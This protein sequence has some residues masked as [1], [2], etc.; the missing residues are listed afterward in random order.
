MELDGCPRS[1]QN[2]VVDVFLENPGLYSK[3]AKN[4]TKCGFSLDEHI[5][6]EIDGDETGSIG[7]HALECDSYK[8]FW[9]IFEQVF[10]KIGLKPSQICGHRTP[11]QYSVR[12][13]NDSRV[14]STAISTHRN[15]SGFPFTN[16]CTRWERRRVFNIVSTALSAMSEDECQGRVW[17]WNDISLDLWESLAEEGIDL[18]KPT[19]CLDWPDARGVFLSNGRSLQVMIN[20]ED[21]IGITCAQQGGNL[22]MLKLR[23]A[24][25]CLS[26]QACLLSQNV[27][28]AYDHNLGH[29]TSNVFKL[30]VGLKVSVIFS[31]VHLAQEEFQSVLEDVCSRYNMVAETCSPFCLE[32]DDEESLKCIFKLSSGASL[33][34]SENQILCESADCMDMIFKIDDALAGSDDEQF[35]RLL[36]SLPPPNERSTLSQSSILSSMTT[37]SHGDAQPGTKSEFIDS[38]RLQSFSCAEREDAPC[39]LSV[40]MASLLRRSF[41]CCMPFSDFVGSA[42][43][44]TSADGPPCAV[45]SAPTKRNPSGIDGRNTS[46]YLCVHDDEGGK[47]RDDGEEKPRDGGGKGEMGSA[48]S[49][50]S[51]ELSFPDSDPEGN[52]TKANTAGK[53]AAAAAPAVELQG[54]RNASC[55]TRGVPA[56]A[57]AA[58]GPLDLSDYPA[59]T[60]SHR[61]LMAMHLTRE[62]YDLLSE[63]STANG[64]TIAQAIRPGKPL[65]TCISSIVTLSRT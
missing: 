29:M 39:L 45:I 57:A 54:D 2:I 15:L 21:H 18:G 31:L 48:A 55:K 35:L 46:A 17:G 63:R 4:R 25:A 58:G 1:P 27:T 7:I 37:G 5:Q 8:T 50:P 65:P 3:I 30:G 13:L 36:Q 34:K 42:D 16:A 62:V 44:P 38:T 22:E 59:F 19:G 6:G 53:P 61:S 11:L 60:A 52:G 9:F 56:A 24:A 28:F 64:F 32:D 23:L 49:T 26:I 12:S 51:Y 47:R 14:I 43:S 33:G 10:M 41:C 20:V 40:K